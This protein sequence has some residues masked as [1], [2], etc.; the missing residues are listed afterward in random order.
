[1]KLQLTPQSKVLEIGTGSGY[2]AAVLAHL[3]PHVYSIEIIQALAETARAALDAQGYKTVQTRRGDGY[4]GWEQ[5]APFDAIIVTA[6]AGHVPPPLWQ[7]LAPGGRM[8]IPIGG[9]YEVQRL[10]VLTKQPDG[11]RKSQTVTA[12]RFVP[13]TGQIQ[14]ER[15]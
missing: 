2:Q 10:V 8:V 11:S 3:T 6:A 15:G 7:Q 5:A 4:Y 12:V 9:P 14:R 13:M 1:E